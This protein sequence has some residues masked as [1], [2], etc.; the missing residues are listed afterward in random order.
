MPQGAFY[1]FPETPIPD[2]K[3]FCAESVKLN[4]L[5]VPGSAFFGPG[6]VRIA[7]CVDYAVIERSEEAFYKLGKQFT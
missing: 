4:L 7:Y 5:L 6:H 3:A 1:L 2:D